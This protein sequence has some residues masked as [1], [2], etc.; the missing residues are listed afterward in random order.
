MVPL[1]SISRMPPPEEGGDGV[2]RGNGDGAVG[3]VSRMPP[4]GERRH[5]Y[6]SLGEL[7]QAGCR[8]RR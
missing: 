6:E 8:P 3:S 7:W 1:G 4:G 5:R 2:R